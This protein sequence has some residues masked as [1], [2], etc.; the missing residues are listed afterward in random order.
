[1]SSVDKLGIIIFAI[2]KVL[3]I[4]EKQ[5]ILGQLVKINVC[6]KELTNQVKRKE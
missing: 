1:M 3:E 5:C 6:L 4:T 2:D